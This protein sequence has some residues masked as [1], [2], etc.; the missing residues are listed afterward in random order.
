MSWDSKE[1]R[2]FVRVKFPC[3]ITVK[4]PERH[5]ISLC[6]ENISAGGIRFLSNEKIG[7]SLLINIELYGVAKKPIVCNGKV[8]W[9]FTR[10][11]PS[12]GKQNIYDIGVEFYQLKKTD[13]AE[14]KSFVVSVLSDKKE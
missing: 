14:I 12:E 1:R 2:E 8:K 6:T 11:N 7:L 3:E 10:K 9:A 5:T 13:L 4:N